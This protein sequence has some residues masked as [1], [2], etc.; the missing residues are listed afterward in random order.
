MQIG[1]NFFQYFLDCLNHFFFFIGNNLYLYSWHYMKG[2]DQKP[3]YT[4]D[5]I[6]ASWSLSSNTFVLKNKS[7]RSHFLADVVQQEII[8]LLE[9]IFRRLV[10]YE[11]IY[12]VARPSGCEKHRQ[13]L[14]IPSATDLFKK[15]KHILVCN[16]TQTQCVILRV[17][18]F[19]SLYVLMERCVGL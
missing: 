8:H 7:R 2:G 12:D 6:P 18:C 13:F 9:T 17:V 3:L 1:E 14:Y 15:L 11:W 19:V 4:A 16:F 10:D 5:C